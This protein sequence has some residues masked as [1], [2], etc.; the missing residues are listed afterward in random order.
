VSLFSAGLLALQSAGAQQPAE[1]YSIQEKVAKLTPET[2]VAVHLSDGNT[3]RGRIAS[4]N[5]NGFVLR[6][7]NGAAEQR[8]SYEQVRNLEAQAPHSNKKKWIILGVAAGA[9]TVV[10]V[11]AIHI[12]NHPLGT[13]SGF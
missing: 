6:L 2:H 3:L 8:I 13:G 11:V 5:D 12:K 9:L 10:A 4:H 7:D 1:S